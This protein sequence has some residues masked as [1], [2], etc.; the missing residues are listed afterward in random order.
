MA[1]SYKDILVFLSAGDGAPARLDGA[2]ALAK[3]HGARLTGVD[4]STEAVF[5]SDR[6]ERATG[7]QDMFEQQLQTAGLRGLFRTAD[8]SDSAGWK[9]LYAHYADLVIAPTVNEAEARLVLPAVPEEV[10]LSAGVPVLLIPDLWKPEKLGRRVVVAWNAS[11]EATRALHDALP[12]LA[13]AEAV[14]L[15][16]YD[17]HQAVMQEEMDLLVAHLAEHGVS[18]RPFTWPASSDVAPIDALFSC[19]SEEDADLIV[20]GGYGRSRRLEH[21]FGGVSETLVNSLTVPVLMSH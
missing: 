20:A 4:V 12:L 3:E 18:A 5:D 8:R 10:L 19:L 1:G 17:A 2:I 14:T 9:A 15:F 16:A 21:L 11:R 7:L 13:R 6:S